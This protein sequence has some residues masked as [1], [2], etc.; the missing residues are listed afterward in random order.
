VILQ[1]G[2]L[3]AQSDIFFGQLLEAA[4]ILHILLDLDSLFRRN[5]LGEL[6]AV[7]EALEHVIGPAGGLGT[8]SAGVEELLAQGTATK[9]VNGLHLE[10]EGLP[11]LQEG[12]EIGFHGL[13]VSI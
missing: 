9:A 10:E 5:A 1:A 3:I 12:I 6:L 4:I 2:D 13:N 8:G 11:L 7:K